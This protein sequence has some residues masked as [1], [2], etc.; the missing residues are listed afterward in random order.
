MGRG[1]AFVSKLTSLDDFRP[2]ICFLD[3][4]YDADSVVSAESVVSPSSLAGPVF[5]LQSSMSMLVDH[6]HR[7]VGMIAADSPSDLLDK[8]TEKL[9]IL[10]C[11]VGGDVCVPRVNCIFSVDDTAGGLCRDKDCNDRRSSGGKG[12]DDAHSI[13]SRN[14]IGGS[15]S[16][17]SGRCSIGI[18]SSRNDIDVRGSN[19]TDRRD[20]V[21]ALAEGL[22][23]GDAAIGEND[24][25]SRLLR[26]A[27]PIRPLSRRFPPRFD[28]NCL[29]SCSKVCCARHLFDLLVDGNVV[30]VYSQANHV[31]SRIDAYYSLPVDTV[32][33]VFRERVRELYRRYCGVLRC[34]KRTGC[35]LSR[36]SLSVPR[37]PSPDYAVSAS[38]VR[39]PSPEYAASAPVVRASSS[40]DAVSGSIAPSNLDR[41]ER[42][43][44]R[45]LRCYCPLQHAPGRLRYRRP[46]PS[47]RPL[48]L[49]FPVSPV[50]RVPS[51]S[52]GCRDTD[53]S[54]S[55][56]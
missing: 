52:Y 44:S 34:D 21:R 40:E 36:V 7:L 33:S 51:P 4:S 23:C 8:V 53:R 16:S 45:V 47:K 20:R 15:N 29:K 6:L 35:S 9:R 22:A 26:Y 43:R 25:S 17:G 11:L 28:L 24:D 1:N 50:S 48:S 46:V 13:R 42:R 38:G 54:S 49:S 12:N 32:C 27:N 37:V 14:S 39:V 18:D 41:R 2:R 5:R 19:C 31:F 56:E 3:V 30:L 55:D 10:I